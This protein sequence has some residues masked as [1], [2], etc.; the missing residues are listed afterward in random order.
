MTSGFLT[1][2]L[3]V[4]AL[5][6]AGV[7]LFDPGGGGGSGRDGRPPARATPEDGFVSLTGKHLRDG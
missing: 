6:T 7:A 1:E 5:A 2:L 3:L 4:L